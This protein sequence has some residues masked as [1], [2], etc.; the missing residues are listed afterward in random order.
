MSDIKF[1][2]SG[3]SVKYNEHIENFIVDLKEKEV[4][5]NSMKEVITCIDNW[6]KK[7]HEI[8]K[9]VRKKIEPKKVYKKQTWDNSFVE[10][11]ITSRDSSKSGCCGGHKD[12]WVKD[13][14]GNREKLSDYYIYECCEENNKLIAKQVALKKESE[15]IQFIKPDLK[16]FDATDE[17]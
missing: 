5:K 17:E 8:K 16:E 12:Y 15:G 7:S 3:Y 4:T 13:S 9:G 10:I 11:W 6:E 2:Y 14:K 1:E